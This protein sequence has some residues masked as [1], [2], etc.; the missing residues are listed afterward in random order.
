L[1]SSEFQPQPQVWLSNDQR[2]VRAWDDC[3]PEVAFD[4]YG[5]FAT[6][7]R[8]M[9]KFDERTQHAQLKAENVHPDDWRWKFLWLTPAHFSECREFSILMHTVKSAV[10]G[11]SR[12]DAR[13]ISP[14]QRWGI[15]VR[16][17]FTCKYCGRKPP[18][19]AL[20]VDHFV[21]VDA[22][23]TKEPGNLVTACQDCNSGKSNRPP[24]KL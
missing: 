23:G 15:F 2:E 10:R 13:N 14:K 22:D 21:S 3:C 5:V 7:G 19:V 4:A 1:F 6:H 17:S 20:T 8:F 24:P 9:D 18:E 11:G 16:D 12:R